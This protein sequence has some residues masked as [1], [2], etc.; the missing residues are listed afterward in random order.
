MEREFS[1]Q[2]Y[3]SAPRFRKQLE[4]AQKGYGAGDQVTTKIEIVAAEGGVPKGKCSAVGQLQGQE[5]YRNDNIELQSDG[6]TLFT[7]S[8][9][10]ELPEESSAILIVTIDDGSITES[11]S[12]TI[13]ILKNNI[14]VSFYPEGGKIIENLVNFVYFEAVMNSEDPADIDAVIFEKSPQGCET[15]IQRFQSFHEG[16]G[17][18]SF[19]PK[20]EH[21]Y[22]CE[23]I[24]PDVGDYE[25]K[26]PE[27]LENGIVLHATK[28]IYESHENLSVFVGATNACVLLAQ[29]FK[30]EVLVYSEE[31]NFSEEILEQSKLY[32]NHLSTPNVSVYGNSLP[33]ESSNVSDVDLS[34]FAG[35]SLPSDFFDSFSSCKFTLH[36]FFYHLILFN[37]SISTIRSTF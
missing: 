29:V 15:P 5:F 25:A 24:R 6:F 4:F 2:H 21:S 37:Y 12:K 18:F 23:I 8:L 33:R 17:K 32:L 30:K 9:P 34:L 19:T 35:D 7:F 10:D 31:L 14:Q 22:R 28:E 11:I 16:R 13:P 36:C 20:S 27:I 26:L 1:I 3:S